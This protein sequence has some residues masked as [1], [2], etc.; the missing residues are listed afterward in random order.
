MRQI[1]IRQ[2]NHPGKTNYIKFNM[3]SVFL[4]NDS[5][6]YFS[7]IKDAKQFLAET[8]RFLNLKLHEFNQVYINIL[9]EYQR[10]WFYFDNENSRS[11][12]NQACV[13]T[14]ISDNIQAIA[15][16]MNFMVTRSGSANGNYY[17]FSNFFNCLDYGF[18]I[19]LSLIDMLKQRRHYIEIKSLEILSSQLDKIRQDITGY[20]KQQQA[21]EN[22][23]EMEFIG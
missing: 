13:E 7:N 5:K 16:A 21:D 1:A 22:R 6:N 18:E 2:V 20:G 19:V 11:V 4:G 23:S 15:K 3:Y 8:N 12:K 17:T 9:A 14:K 10:N